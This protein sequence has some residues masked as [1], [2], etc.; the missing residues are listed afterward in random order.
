[1]LTTLLQE[2][3]ERMQSQQLPGDNWKG[4]KKP[5]TFLKVWSLAGNYSRPS[6]DYFCQIFFLSTKLGNI[7]PKMKTKH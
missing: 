1:M 7:S 5:L 6:R 3:S 2:I 4:D